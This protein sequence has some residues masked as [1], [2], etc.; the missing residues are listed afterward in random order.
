MAPPSIAAT[1]PW[2]TFPWHRS[3]AKVAAVPSDPTRKDNP[4]R[5]PVFSM[6]VSIYRLI[7][8]Y[9]GSDS[10]TSAHTRFAKPLEKHEGWV[11]YGYRHPRGTRMGYKWNWESLPDPATTT[12][13]A[14]LDHVP[15]QTLKTFETFRKRQRTTALEL[16]AVPQILCGPAHL[17]TLHSFHPKR[18]RQGKS[19]KHSRSH[20]HLK[21]LHY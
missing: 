7:S 11:V 12:L 6:G 5:I 17:K 19:P 15:S 13:V 16:W 1:L 14:K 4:S 18:K 20:H 10:N 8:M 9:N 2:A 3:T 21:T